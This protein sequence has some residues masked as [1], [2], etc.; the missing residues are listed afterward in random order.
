MRSSSYR[1]E[2]EVRSEL[3]TGEGE[4][5]QPRYALGRYHEHERIFG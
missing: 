1:D 5:L 3:G 2:I 4:I